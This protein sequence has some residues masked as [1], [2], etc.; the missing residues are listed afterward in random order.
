[1]VGYAPKWFKGMKAPLCNNGSVTDS[2]NMPEQC[3][4]V[5]THDLST[6]RRRV[7]NKAYMAKWYRANTNYQERCKER[8]KRQWLEKKAA[9]SL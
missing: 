3:V 1:M 5:D 4:Q 9:K 8:S 7:Y 2:T 6:W